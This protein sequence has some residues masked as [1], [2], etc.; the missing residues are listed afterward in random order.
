MKSEYASYFSPMTT[1]VNHDCA[2]NVIS[3]FELF[4]PAYRA[5]FFVSV[6]FARF[7]RRS[8]SVAPP[9]GETSR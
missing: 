9:A 6:E 1:W 7:R 8:R 3:D 4:A 5:T 2:N